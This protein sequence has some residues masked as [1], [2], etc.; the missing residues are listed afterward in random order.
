MRNFRLLILFLASVCF[1]TG[2]VG[3]TTKPDTLNKNKY[4]NPKKATILAL[5][6]PGAG[7]IYNKKYWKLPIL[8]GGFVALAYAFDFNHQEYRFYRT[9]YIAATDGDSSTEPSTFGNADFFK[10]NRNFYKK[11]RDLA[12]IGAFGL[13]AL[14]IIDA[15]VDAHLTNFKLVDDMELSIKP[16]FSP[17]DWASRQ[18]YYGGLKLALQ[19]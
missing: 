9:Q 18:P 11:N 5:A 10:S 6:L 8:Y 19:F 4:P 3:Q 1:S 14:Q 16:S 17:V 2:L 12:V 7:Q 15:H 13:Y